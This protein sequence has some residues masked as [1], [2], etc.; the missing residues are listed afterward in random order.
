MKTKYYSLVTK[1]HTLLVLLLASVSLMAQDGDPSPPDIDGSGGVVGGGANIHG[2]LSIVFILTALYG[3][4]VIY[5][6]YRQRK[7]KLA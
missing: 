7:G 5:R 4:Y 1:I 3:G 6:I 2:G